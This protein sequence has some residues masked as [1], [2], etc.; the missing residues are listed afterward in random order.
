MVKYSTIAVDNFSEAVNKVHNQIISF[1][2][3]FN[4][5]EVSRYESYKMFRVKM[6]RKIKKRL[7][8]A[9]INFYKRFPNEDC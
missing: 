6:P 3:R 2:K 1:R 9:Y 4:I 8:K 7:K 5:D